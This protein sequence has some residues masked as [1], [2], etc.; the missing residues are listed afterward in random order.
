MANALK[1]GEQLHLSF[2]VHLAN[3]IGSFDDAYYWLLYAESI[4][5]CIVDITSQ[6]H[7]WIVFISNWITI[8]MMSEMCGIIG[9]DI[10]CRQRR[11]ITHNPTAHSSHFEVDE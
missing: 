4:C 11:A 2:G 1:I 9:P 5:D 7:A 6:W 10:L 3:K 8:Q